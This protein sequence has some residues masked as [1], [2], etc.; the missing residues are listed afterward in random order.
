[1]PVGDCSECLKL[2]QNI[3]RA[4]RLHMEALSR[5]E[6]A[7]QKD[8]TDDEFVSLRCA[9]ADCALARQEALDRYQIHLLSHER[10]TA[11][12]GRV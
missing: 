2:L 1:M 9:V 12:A 11:G 6:V 10:R 7:V 8:V 5:I 4:S 3:A